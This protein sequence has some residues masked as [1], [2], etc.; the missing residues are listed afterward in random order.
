V[1]SPLATVLEPRNQP[2]LVNIAPPAPPQPHGGAQPHPQRP[3]LLSERRRPRG[4]TNLLLLAQ[5]V[6]ERP[7]RYAVRLLK[8]RSE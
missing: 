6:A 7:T 8:R 2:A 1:S 5:A 4:V 3:S